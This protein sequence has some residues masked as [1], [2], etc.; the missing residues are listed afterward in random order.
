MK[1]ER[2]ETTEAEYSV[3]DIFSEIRETALRERLSSFT[4]YRDLIDEIVEEK[5]IYG[6]FDDDE[7]T[8][9]IKKDLELMWPETKDVLEKEAGKSLA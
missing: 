3:R 5:R 2:I 7:D 9:Q 1:P 6:L 4:Q 8:T